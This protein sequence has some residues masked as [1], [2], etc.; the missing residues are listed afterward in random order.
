MSI[1]N[2][3]IVLLPLLVLAC[4]GDKPGG[5][6]GDHILKV[7]KW[8]PSGDLQTDTVGQT[9]PKVIR[10]K[11]TLDGNTVGGV[12]VHFDGGTLGS[13]TV[14]TGSNGIA[15]STWTLETTAGVQEVTATVDSAEGSPLTFHATAIPGPATAL[16]MTT[17]D[18]QA[19]DTNQIF[20]LPFGVRVVDAFDNGIQ[21][22]WVKFSSTG[23]IILPADSIITDPNGASDMF[24]TA[25]ATP[26]PITV[27]ATVDGLAGSPIEFTGAVVANA[28]IVN[29]SDGFFNPDSIVITHGAAVKWHWVN[30]GHSVASTG[31]PSFPS[32]DVLNAGDDY[33]PIVFNT[34]GVYHYE[35]AVH[36]GEHGTIVV[37]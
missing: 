5:G 8:T 34:P 18:Q 12:T 25:G 37:Q 36:T 21:G 29:V 7:V 17:G 35:C 4:G 31:S 10:V 26:G 3:P 32:S 9:L 11:V 23:P 33:G 20:D 15:T 16:V 6:G 30:S 24:A 27:T 1:R 19:S 2:I 13:P 14:V 28:T 22:R